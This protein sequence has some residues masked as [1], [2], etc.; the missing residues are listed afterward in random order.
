MCGL[1]LGDWNPGLVMLGALVRQKEPVQLGDELVLIPRH[2]LELEDEHLSRTSRLAEEERKSK[3]DWGGGACYS[4]P[5]RVFSFL[6][7]ASLF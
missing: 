1:V 2:Q 5:M 7:W 4:V 3:G 6:S